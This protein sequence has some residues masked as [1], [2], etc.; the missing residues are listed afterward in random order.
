MTA[1]M[2]AAQGA[3]ADSGKARE[4]AVAA[5]AG[6]VP[7]SVTKAAIGTHRFRELACVPFG[8]RV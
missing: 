1:K 8:E 7:R 6:E 3:L 2:D 4:R 5:T